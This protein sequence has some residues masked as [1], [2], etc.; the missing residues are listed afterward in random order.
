VHIPEL[1]G[2]SCDVLV[3]ANMSGYPQD[4]SSNQVESH[5]Q[6]LQNALAQLSLEDQRP[7][8]AALAEAA[9]GYMSQQTSDRHTA[10]RL[11]KLWGKLNVPTSA[12]ITS[13]LLEVI[14]VEAANGSAK[15]DM[16]VT[17]RA[18]LARIA[19]APPVVRVSMFAVSSGCIHVMTSPLCP[20][21]PARGATAGVESGAAVHQPGS[22]RSVG[23][24]HFG[25]RR[26]LAAQDGARC[27]RRGHRA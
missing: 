26:S 16:A 5:K 17:L 7:H 1:Q 27:D 9:L 25:V 22:R 21:T 20:L 11:L 3:A 15:V 10:A 2:F 12:G 6:H 19:L 18:A 13:Y 23:A 8:T 4:G 24:A 14:A